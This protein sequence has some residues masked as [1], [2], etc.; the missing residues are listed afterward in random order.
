MSFSSFYCR[1]FKSST[2][3]SL[4][5]YYSLL[6][7]FKNRR[8]ELKHSNK[9]TSAL[10]FTSGTMWHPCDTD[11]DGCL[12]GT[13]TTKWCHEVKEKKEKDITCEKTLNTE[14][15]GG[16]YS[17]NTH[18]VHGHVSAYNRCSVHNTHTHTPQSSL[19][20]QRTVLRGS[21]RLVGRKGKPFIFSHGTW[22][23]LILLSG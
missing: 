16:G 17:T 5:S 11:T 21:R 1:S 15:R 4:F 2:W 19:I 8:C 13:G 23:V 3:I 10:H 20:M 12:I 22:F 6:K 14:R 18:T 7:A 9:Y